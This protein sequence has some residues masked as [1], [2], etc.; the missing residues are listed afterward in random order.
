[1]ARSITEALRPHRRTWQ[2][3]LDDVGER[4]R[5]ELETYKKQQKKK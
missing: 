3:H 5:A 1:V 4:K 2:K